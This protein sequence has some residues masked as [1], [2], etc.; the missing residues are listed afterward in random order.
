MKGDE[1][2]VKVCSVV[3]VLCRGWDVKV[4]CEMWRVRWCQVLMLVLGV[5][6]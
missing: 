6:C 3:G 1:C 4:R 5:R 2:G